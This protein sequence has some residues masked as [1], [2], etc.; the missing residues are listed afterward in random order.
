M[1]DILN[2]R[3]GMEDNLL[4]I[5]Q[6]NLMK[7]KEGEE[8]KGFDDV[9]LQAAQHH[10]D[11]INTVYVLGISWLKN[12]TDFA[13]RFIQGLTTICDYW[14]NFKRWNL[15]NVLHVGHNIRE[16]LYFCQGIEDSVFLPCYSEGFYIC[17]VIL[18]I[19][20]FWGFCFFFILF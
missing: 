1:V 10:I 19:L 14:K 7:E 3:N 8:Q 18:R 20:Y 17:H 5:Q 4:L 13:L 12:E 2:L 11:S 16:I 15:V 9:V 6:I